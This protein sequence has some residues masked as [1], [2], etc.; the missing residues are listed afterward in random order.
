MLCVLNNINDDLFLSIWSQGR[1]M[2]VSQS[3]LLQGDKNPDRD[4]R[5]VSVWAGVRA[6]GVFYGERYITEAEPDQASFELR[7]SE[8]HE[9]KGKVVSEMC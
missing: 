1:E 5:P 8:Q 6:G 7:I 3:V 4:A 2:P 9:R